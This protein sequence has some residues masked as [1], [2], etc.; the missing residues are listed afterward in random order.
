VVIRDEHCV[1]VA[2]K[3]R[4]Y[5]NLSNV[6]MSE[7]VAVRDGLRVA[8]AMGFNKIIVKSDSI[9]LISLL[10]SRDG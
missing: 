9:N 5:K 6:L 4:F 7:A 3:A 10:N 8:I 1:F 2:A